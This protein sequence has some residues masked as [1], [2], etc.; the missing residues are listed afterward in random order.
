MKMKTV[1]AHDLSFQLLISEEQIQERV[2]AIGVALTTQY[3]GKK[4]IFIGILNGA[5]I[6][7]AD[8]MRAC[9]MDC[10]LA[11]IQLSSYEG[12]SSSGEIKTVM[13]LN[14]DVKDRHVI[15]A[16]DIIDTGNTLNQFIPSLEKLNPASISLT[17]LLLKPDALQH[18]LNIHHVGFEIPNLFVIGYGLDYDNL[19]RNLKGIYQLQ[20]K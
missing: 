13:D 3:K 17:T 8:L 12:L 6:Y 11:F 16:E 18:S 9:D 20:K 4:P 2:N 7:M 14:I 19:G 10:E 1:T 15:I 5:F